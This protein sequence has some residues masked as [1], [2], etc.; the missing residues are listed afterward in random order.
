MTICIH[1]TSPV[2][3]ICGTKIKTRIRVHVLFKKMY[4]KAN[5]TNFGMGD[6]DQI[7]F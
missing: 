2:P 3:S 5:L 1:M 4:T 7:F 6:L